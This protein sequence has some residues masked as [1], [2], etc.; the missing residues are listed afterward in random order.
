M[1]LEGEGGVIVRESFK[2]GLMEIWWDLNLGLSDN[3][4]CTLPLDNQDM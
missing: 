4:L 1:Q 2:K 3:W